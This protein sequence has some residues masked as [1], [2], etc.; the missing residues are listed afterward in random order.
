MDSTDG[1]IRRM[2]GYMDSTHGWKD[3]TQ[4]GFYSPQLTTQIPKTIQVPRIGGFDFDFES[5][6]Y[7]ILFYKSMQQKNE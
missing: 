4:A 1:W 2:D 6:T 3:G 5:K 7:L